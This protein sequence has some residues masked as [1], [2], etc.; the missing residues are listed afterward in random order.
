MD[1]IAELEKVGS[2]HT[3][4]KLRL[5]SQ[6]GNTRVCAYGYVCVCVAVWCSVL[7]VQATLGCALLGT[8]RVCVCARVC[9]CVC[10]CARVCVRVRVCVCACVCVRVRA[11]VCACLIVIVNSREW[12]TQ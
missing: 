8:V 3:P 6:I 1:T 7:Q 11:F 12:G 10:V 9:V 2:W 5:V 4:Q